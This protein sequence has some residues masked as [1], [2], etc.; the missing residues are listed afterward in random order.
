MYDA[1]SIDLPLS[2]FVFHIFLLTMKVMVV[3][4]LFV[5]LFQ[6]NIVHDFSITPPAVEVNRLVVE[7]M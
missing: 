7:Y 5:L 2:S 1:L 3:Y 6:K 4:Q